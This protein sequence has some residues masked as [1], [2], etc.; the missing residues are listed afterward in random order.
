MECEVKKCKKEAIFNLYRI[1]ADLSK[2]WLNVCDE[3]EQEISHNN[4][5]LQGYNPISG[6]EAKV[7]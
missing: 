3:C 2:D 1:N 7:K 6:M 5:V 4:M